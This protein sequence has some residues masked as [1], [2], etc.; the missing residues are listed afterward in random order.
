MLASLGGLMLAAFLAATPIPMQSEAVFIALQLAGTAPVG[1][2][3]LCAG[4]ANTA[5]SVV[6]WASGRGL[7]AMEGRLRIPQA[8]LARAE[9]FYRRWGLWTLLLSWA[10]G[11]DVIC[12]IAGAL[13]VPLWQFGLVVGLVKTARY[14]LVA[15]ATA[16]MTAWLWT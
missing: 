16:G 2:M 9:T 8:Q 3:I 10:P 4:L 12:F 7:R 14:A 11:G 5:G 6:T 13:R 1:L 15:A